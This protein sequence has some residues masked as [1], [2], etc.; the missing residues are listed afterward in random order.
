MNPVEGLAINGKRGERKLGYGT[1]NFRRR[2]H[3]RFN[4]DLPVE[5]GRTELSTQHGRASNVSEGGLL[6]YLPEQMKI[7]EH[8]MLK[9]F[10]PFDSKLQT[11]EILVQVAWVDIPLE[12]DWGLYRTGVRFVDISLDDLNKMRNFLRDLFG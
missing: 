2:K 9:L 5:Y 7:G 6:L 3:P 4:V 11:T 12:K 8:L 1:V 10:L